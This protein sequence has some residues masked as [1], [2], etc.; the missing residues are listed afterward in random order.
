MPRPDGLLTEEE[1]E[2]RRVALTKQLRDSAVLRRYRRL[3]EGFKKRLAK[4]WGEPLKLYEIVLKGTLDGGREFAQGAQ[5]DQESDFTFQALVSLHAQ[6]CRVA[7]EVLELLKAGHARGAH[8]RCRTLHELAVFAGVIAEHPEVAER[9]LLHDAI[10]DARSLDT[11]QTKLAGRPGYEPYSKED[12]DFVHARRDEVLNRCGKSFGDG[13]YGW[14][15][16]LFPPKAHL[17]FE[18]LEDLARLGHLRPFY[19]WATHLGVHASS[20]GVR[21]NLITQG[22]ITTPLA[23]ATNIGL[24]DPGHEALISLLQVTTSLM[25]HGK[26][27]TDDPTPVVVLKALMTL[28]DEAGEAFVAVEERIAEEEAQVQDDAK[29]RLER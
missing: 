4:K 29:R 20:R 24:S 27:I 5:A 17:T 22:D 26:P 2:R 23:G 13:Y 19:D 18:K 12:V 11:Y 16:P 21:L 3:G 28:T 10:E 25:V 14:A 6:A 8:A 7:G 9:F 1:I 15:A